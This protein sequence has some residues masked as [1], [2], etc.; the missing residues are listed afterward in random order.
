MFFRILIILYL[1]N[2]WVDLVD[3]TP[4][5]RNWYEVLFYSTLTSLSDL[6]V[7]VMDFKLRLQ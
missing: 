6:E 2:M 4:V 7:K 5:V 3:S 1:F